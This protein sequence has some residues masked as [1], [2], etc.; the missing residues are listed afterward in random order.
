MDRP[1]PPVTLAAVAAGAE[2]RGDP[3]THVVDAAD[4]SRDTRPGSLFFCIRGRHHD[5]H[6]LAHVAAARGASALVVERWLDDIEIPQIRVASVREA[7]GPMAA[8]VFGDPA[9]SLSLVGITGTNGKTTTTYLLEAV[10]RAAGWTPG[11]IGTTGARIDGHAEA[12][13]RTTPEAPDLH[14]LLARMLRAGVDTVAMEVSSHALAQGRTGGAVCDVAV[15]TNLSQD[16]LD[17]HTSMESYFEAKSRLFAPAMARHGVIN[18][19]DP[20]GQKLA[21]RGSIPVTTY[22]LERE[23][24]L[25]G[26][27]VH[28][29]AEGL[30]FVVDGI[31]V[32]SH[33][34]GRFNAWNCLS[35]FATGRVL[36][37]DAAVV[38]GARASVP[39]VPGRM[40]LVE[41]GQEFL[42]VVDYAHTPD[43]ILGVLRG[44][45]PLATGRVIVVFGCG[46]DRDRAKR[47]EMGRAATSEADLTVVTSDNP[48]SEDPLAIIGSILPGADAGGGAYVVEPDRRAAIRV[49]VG[50]ARPGDVV[51]I[52]GRGHETIQE[53]RGGQ[54]PFD[55]R[56]VVREEIARTRV[57]GGTP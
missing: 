56:V 38:A 1:F 6:D 22:A 18:V 36:G 52:A 7:M 30:S 43:S 21:E 46:G 3:E 12:L 4:D 8:T 57:G 24:D 39:G 19:D 33:L 13:A 28:A 20:W 32:R 51:V 29:D 47:P 35:A 25:C 48:R 50:E 16:H 34:L 40:E 10:F 54:A 53:T 41:A 5:G 31:E 44:A 14:R 45:R 27:D 42:V 23:A 9:S 15:F 11:V 49:A 26:R 17:Y 55:D 37:I 2:I